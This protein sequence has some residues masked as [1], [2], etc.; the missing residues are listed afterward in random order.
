MTN[1]NT[2]LE[3]VPQVKELSKFELFAAKAGI[4]VFGLV[5]NICCIELL[6]RS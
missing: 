3:T 6:I 5:I 2:K 4:A 1:S